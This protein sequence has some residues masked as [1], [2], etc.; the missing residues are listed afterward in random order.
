MTQVEIS[1]KIDKVAWIDNFICKQ[2]QES[3]LKSRNGGKNSSQSKNS[4]NYM[5][6]AQ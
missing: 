1:N 4:R 6:T 2:L 3:R 5:E